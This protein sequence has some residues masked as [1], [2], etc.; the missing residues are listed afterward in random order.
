[1]NRI[2]AAPR[3][4]VRLT[5]RSPTGAVVAVRQ[6]RNTVLRNGARLIAR[7][8]TGQGGQAIN[9]LQLGFAQQEASVDAT[10]LTQANPPLDVAV[11]RADIPSAAFTI[12]TAPPDL[13]RV[14]VNALFT[15]SVTLTDVTEAGLMAHD[16]LYNQV[17]F[18]P[19]TLEPGQNITFFW[20][21]DFP[22]GH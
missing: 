19:V 11:L 22:F 1:M 10:S 4:R 3:G 14:S 16:E 20:Q 21:I 15:P 5:V 12:D 2:T 6:A 17:V 13:V 9:R 18:E 7:L 8:C